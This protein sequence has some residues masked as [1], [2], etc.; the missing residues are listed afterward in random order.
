MV[1]SLVLS[2]ST[3]RTYLYSSGDGFK[4]LATG[5]YL[6]ACLTQVRILSVENDMIQLLTASTDGHVVVWE[7][8]RQLEGGLDLRMVIVERMHQSSVKS[9][10]I[11][12]VPPPPG[13]QRSW[14]VI[15]GGDDNALGIMDLSWD[16]C[17]GARSKSRVKG[18][19]AAAVTGTRVI[20]NKEE[21]VVATVSNDQRVKVWR[22]TFA[23]G[24]KGAGRIQ[25][26]LLENRYSSVADPGDVEVIAPGRL[27]VGGVGMEVWEFEGERAK[28][29]LPF[30]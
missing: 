22:V 13:H 19:H 4:L 3:V 11:A 15:T 9:L 16:G 1:I 10:S 7:S 23:D 8:R 17:F 25:V 12:A 6:G 30:R 21:V 5:E 26:A 29:M 27:M 28:A 20:R 14:L 18:A 24:D 2:N